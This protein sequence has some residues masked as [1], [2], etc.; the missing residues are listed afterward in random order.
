M[1]LFQNQGAKLSNP[2]LQCGAHSL[3]YR[4]ALDLEQT[5]LARAK[6]VGKTKKVKR[7][8]LALTLPLAVSDCEGPESGTCQPVL[9][10]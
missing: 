5:V 3:L 6:E 4:H 8:G 7:L 1:D 9:S 2:G 10:Q